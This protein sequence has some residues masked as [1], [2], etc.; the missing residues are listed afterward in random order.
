MTT[1]VGSIT[2]TPTPGD[3]IESAWAQT[4]TAQAHH[5]FSSKAALDAWTTA[6]LG[7]VAITMDNGVQWKKLGS[8]WCRLTPWT[9]R[10]AGAAGIFVSSLPASASVSVVVPADPGNRLVIVAAYVRCD[11]T[12]LVATGPTGM[13]ELT[14]NG[15]SISQWWITDNGVRNT[16]QI[17]HRVVADGAA[18]T[19]TL[20][21]GVSLTP[22]AHTGTVQVYG[23]DGLHRLEVTAHPV[24]APG[25]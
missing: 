2:T 25:V 6:P 21:V 20:T 23:S 3:P 13:V 15:V 24:P 22:A 10:V 9:A 12:N 14:D 4:V 8:G 17:V 19:I 18:H 11:C 16:C 1:T 5:I 7:A